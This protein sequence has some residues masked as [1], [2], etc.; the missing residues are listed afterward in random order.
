MVD[1][2]GIPTGNKVTSFGV[3][4]PQNQ[5]FPNKKSYQGSCTQ[6]AFD[7][8]FLVFPRQLNV[9]FRPGSDLREYLLNH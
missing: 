1:G 9:L 2:I 7:K 3:L 6:F 5:L 4:L 8:S